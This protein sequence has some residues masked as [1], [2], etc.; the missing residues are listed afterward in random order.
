MPMTMIY[1]DEM[2]HILTSQEA[3]QEIGSRLS[4]HAQC[5]HINSRA[6]C[7]EASVAHSELVDVIA[8]PGIA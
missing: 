7:W 6:Y 2:I 3:M 4:A 1:I 8:F 5:G